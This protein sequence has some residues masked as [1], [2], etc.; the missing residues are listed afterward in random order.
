MACFGLP[1]LKFSWHA[2]LVHSTSRMPKAYR[3]RARCRRTCALDSASAFAVAAR[4]AA[5]TGSACAACPLAAG[6]PACISF[7]HVR[8]AANTACAQVAHAAC[9]ESAANAVITTSC[10]VRHYLN[11]SGCPAFQKTSQSFFQ[12]ACMWQ[13]SCQVPAKGAS[14]GSL[15]GPTGLALARNASRTR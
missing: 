14:L 6:P 1:D 12:R 5:S 2:E 3:R 4:A 11:K 9:E 8:T 13:L 10:V 7:T 15:Q